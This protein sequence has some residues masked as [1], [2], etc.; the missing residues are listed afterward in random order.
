[1]PPGGPR[2]RDAEGGGNHRACEREADDY[3]T[4]D[5]PRAADDPA[6]PVVVAMLRGHRTEQKAQRLRAGNQWIGSGLVFTTEL[7]APV[8]PRNPLRVIEA[9]AKTA[10]IEGVGIHTLRHSAAVQGGLNAELGL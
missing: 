7:G 3:R 5:R 9:A 10:G 1:M 6:L 8:D 2:R 4:E